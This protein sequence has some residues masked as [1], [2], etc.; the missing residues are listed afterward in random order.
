MKSFKKVFLAL[1]VISMVV[2]GFG[3]VAHAQPYFELL[4]T[5]TINSKT[6][7]LTEDS[8]GTILESI[9]GA[10]TTTFATGAPVGQISITSVVIGSW[11]INSA[12]A[13]TYNVVGTTTAPAFSINSLN[14]VD[15]NA[16]GG[17]LTIAT[18]AIGFGL[19]PS[20]STA[21]IQLSFTNDTAALSEAVYGGNSNNLLDETHQIGTTLN[22]AAGSNGSTNT[23][24]SF[25]PVNP[26]SLTDVMTLTQS[27]TGGNNVTGNLQVVPE[28]ASMLFLGLGIIGA[29]LFSRFR[30][31]GT[32]N[33]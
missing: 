2:I 25:S 24:G 14:A 1:T 12:T 16:A 30:R 29:G 18:S 22:L 26:Y 6:V 5:D 8:S 31:P 9:N 7:A 11:T 21:A 23:S 20:P 15:T 10:P 13:D 3:A 32:K 33:V 28:P 19:T 27:T 17:Q 4:L